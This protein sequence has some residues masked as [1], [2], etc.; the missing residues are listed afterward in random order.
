MTHT[1]CTH[2]HPPTHTHTHTHTHMHTHTCAVCTH[3][4][5]ARV[6]LPLMF[7]AQEPHIPARTWEGRGGGGMGIHGLTVQ[8][9]S[10]LLDTLQT[11]YTMLHQLQGWLV[12]LT[13]SHPPSR[14]D[15]LKVSDGSISFLILINA[16]RTIGPQ[17]LRSTSY[18]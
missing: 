5:H 14:H 2:T 7:M 16:S 10:V 17:E 4:M 13:Q 8:L 6:L 11:N 12:R 1:H 18:V 3:Q 15:L 9:K